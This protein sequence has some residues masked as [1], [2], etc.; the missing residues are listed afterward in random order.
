MAL[1]SYSSNSKSG[2]VTVTDTA[3]SLSTLAS[4]SDAEDS[5]NGIVMIQVAS[6]EAAGIEL[7]GQSGSTGLLIANDDAINS[8]YVDDMSK[9]LLK[10]QG[11]SNISVRWYAF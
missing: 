1:T 11:G 10:R 5:T 8:I 9:I 2:T 7:L 6:T 4:L 3:T